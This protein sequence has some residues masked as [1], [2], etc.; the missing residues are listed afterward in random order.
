MAR[1]GGPELPRRRCRATGVEMRPL[2]SRISAERG[3]PVVLP[4]PYTKGAQGKQPARGADGA[5]GKGGGRKRM[6]CCNG[7]DRGCAAR[8]HDPTRKRAD[9]PL[10]WRHERAC[11]TDFRGRRRYV[12]SGNASWCGPQSWQHELSAPGE[13]REGFFRQAK[14]GRIQA[15]RPHRG[16][17]SGVEGGLDLP[18]RP[19]GATSH[20]GETE[21][22]GLPRDGDRLY[23]PLSA[24]AA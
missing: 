2:H 10:V 19:T 11:Q 9:F 16:C 24:A 13:Y 22:D 7:A 5:A 20:Q 8:Q 1:S 23:R 3:K 21:T 6:P 14:A 4:A 12:G 17:N 18:P 15:I